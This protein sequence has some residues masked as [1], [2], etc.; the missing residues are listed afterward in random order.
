MKNILPIL[1][2]SLITFSCK[3][4]A[5]INSIDDKKSTVIKEVKVKDDK[6][7]KDVNPEKSQ[8]QTVL[9]ENAR[10]NQTETTAK[11]I[12]VEEQPTRVESEKI[13]TQT[14]IT[15]EKVAAETPVKEEIKE[16]KNTEDPTIENQELIADTPKEDISE[17]V[18]EVKPTK[19]EVVVVDI[20]DQWNQLLQTYVSTSGKVD[21]AGLKSQTDKLDAYLAALSGSVP[22]E[23]DLSA[24]AKAFWM[25]AYNAFTVKLILNN[26]P[27]GSITDLHGGKPWDQKWI[28][29]GAKTYSLNNIEHDILRP[30]FKDGRVHFAV[31]CAAKSCP[32]LSNQAFTATNSE[33]MLNSLTK[34]FINNKAANT[35]EKGSVALSKIFDWYGEDFGDLISF[36]NKYSSTKIANDAAIS[37]RD[38]N[39][40]LNS[41]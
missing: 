20:H 8:D 41:K 40:A 28:K 5:P 13:T 36:L 33:Q 2:A 25:N 6:V 4:E 15:E 7:I 10:I 9:I 12:V 16:L 39:W 3:A 35:I 38:Y 29:L 32:K 1:L 11:V 14:E 27:V 37:F 26:Y 19:E 31:N 18:E 21:Y 17:K 34:S 23:S 30:K 22:S 24:K